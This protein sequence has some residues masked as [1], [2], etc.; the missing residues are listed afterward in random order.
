MDIIAQ[1]YVVQRRIGEGGTAVV[2]EATD[3]VLGRP[4]ALK[5]L[6]D[7]GEGPAAELRRER[8]RQEAMA[9]ATLDHPRVVRVYDL[10]EHEGR[11]FLAMEYLARGS[12]ADHLL[13]HGP[14]R[15]SQ[16]VAWMLDV[17]EALAAAH[18]G[19]IVHRDVKPHNVLIRDD[20]SAALADFGIAR[21]EASSHTRTGVALGSVDYM[22]P[23]QRVDARR[24]GPAADLYGAGCTLYHLLT[25]E[26]PVDLYLSPDHSPRWEGLPG[27]LRPIVRRATAVSLADRYG[28]AEEMAADLRAMAPVVQDL[29]PRQPLFS[30]TPA[31]AEERAPVQLTLA[32]TRERGLGV[33]EWSWTKRGVWVGRNSVML[34]M[35]MVFG[36]SLSVA[37][38]WPRVEQ[39]LLR[40]ATAAPPTKAP[41]D[42]AG[43][44]MGTYGEA[45]HAV[46]VSFSG[47]PTAVRGELRM[48][49]D[50]HELRSGLVGK[51][52]ERGVRL[53][54]PDGSF[55][56]EVD[57]FGVLRGELQLGRHAPTPFA[58]V[59][60]GP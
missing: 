37:A 45:R 21:H 15:P 22:A 28:T 6:L 49:I 54:A 46:S 59:R 44:W 14:L 23:E 30:G 56:G 5:W 3:R 29:P 25:A 47:P 16:A 11:P 41:A 10:G 24:A 51:S 53:S 35:L 36:L 12:L 39:R 31:P 26:T 8:L 17:L 19:G 1:R 55:V 9:L 43:R 7:T 42:L 60:V 34:G 52:D 4:C 33:E 13:A 38:I 2:F 27:P 57:A 32:A 20:G 18:E 58:M 50:G 48:D 40:E